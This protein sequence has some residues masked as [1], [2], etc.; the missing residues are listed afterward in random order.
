M[1]YGK[2]MEQIM[3]S[4]EEHFDY[5]LRPCVRSFLGSNTRAFFFFFFPVFILL[6]APDM[7]DMMKVHVHGSYIVSISVTLSLCALLINELR[8]R[9]TVLKLHIDY[10]V[11]QKGIIFK[12][13]DRVYFQDKKHT[14]RKGNYRFDAG[15]WY[16]C[17]RNGGNGRIRGRYF[18][19]R[20]S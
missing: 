19:F 11:Y 8:R 13:I 4:A 7:F 14:Y 12:S 5:I 3:D 16:T 10:L 20:A 15:T 1:N 2:E 18:W 9:N 17:Y 6:L